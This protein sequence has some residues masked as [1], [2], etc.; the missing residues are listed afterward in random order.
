MVI[1]EIFLRF[2]FLNVSPS[3]SV[4]FLRMYHMEMTE[5]W[6]F[7]QFHFLLSSS[8]SAYFSFPLSG[9]SVRSCKFN[10]LKIFIFFAVFLLRFC[11][12]PPPSPL[13]GLKIWIFLLKVENSIVAIS[14]YFQKFLH[15]FCFQVQANSNLIV[16]VWLKKNRRHLK[17]N[18][19][20]SNWYWFWNGKF[21][22]FDLKSIVP[23]Q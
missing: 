8:S 22:N 11:F 18:R 15:Y 19:R 1:M 10:F 3:P 21:S 16:F 6:E 7:Y 14:R 2:E 5:Y 23:Y 13:F 9:F 17:T 20:E 12:P 4:P